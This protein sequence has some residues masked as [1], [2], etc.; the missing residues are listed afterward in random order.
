MAVRIGN[1]FA[2]LNLVSEFKGLFISNTG[3]DIFKYIK[4]RMEIILLLSS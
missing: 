3:F 1:S 2:I 4:I